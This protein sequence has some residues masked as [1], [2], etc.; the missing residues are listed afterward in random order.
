LSIHSDNLTPKEFGSVAKRRTPESIDWSSF[1]LMESSSEH[2]AKN[3]K[4][5]LR[6]MPRISKLK[7]CLIS[8]FNLGYEF[9]RGEL[10]LEG[11]LYQRRMIT[12]VWNTKVS[13]R[14]KYFG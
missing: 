7:L 5:A 12:F 8:I 14:E 13:R 6:A 1:G 4:A 3:K 11:V 10:Q 2:P 9:S